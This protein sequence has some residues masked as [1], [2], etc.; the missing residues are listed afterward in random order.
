MR[1]VPPDPARTFDEGYAI[2]V[3]LLHAGRHGKDVRIEDDVLR[4]KADAVDQDFVGARG[5]RRLALERIGLARFVERHDDDRGAVAAYEL[6]MV[7]KRVLALLKR[8]RIDHRLALHAFQSGFDH[9]EFG[10]VDHQRHAGDVGLRGNE[11]EKRR[12]RLLGIEE[13]LVHVDIED[14]R[15]VFDLVAATA[16]AAG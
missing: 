13:A 3:M 16:R 7:D 2:A 1:Q 11:I 14:L 8:D 6:R 4:R 10:G 9:R 12:H 15:A 5:D